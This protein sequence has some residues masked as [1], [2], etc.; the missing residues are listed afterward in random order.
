MDNSEADPLV[1]RCT[2]IF[3]QDCIAIAVSWVSYNVP[4][5][6]DDGT[7]IVLGKSVENGELMRTVDLTIGGTFDETFSACHGSN[8]RGSWELKI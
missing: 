5:F 2:V 6:T 4:A 3:D 8:Q 7:S 1:P